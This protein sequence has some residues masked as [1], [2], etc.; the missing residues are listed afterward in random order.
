MQ[1]IYVCGYVCVYVLN[2]IFTCEL[3]RYIYYNFT[4]GWEEVS[5]ICLTY[6]LKTRFAVSSKDQLRALPD[7]TDKT[8]YTDANR[9]KKLISWL[10][11]RISRGSYKKDQ[12]RGK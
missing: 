9:L 7:I 8:G 10:F 12:I 6:L 1:Y 3:R 11:D 4:Q 2:F 5:G